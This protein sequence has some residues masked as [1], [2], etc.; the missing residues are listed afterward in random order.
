[1]KNNGRPTKLYRL[2]CRNG[3]YYG[4]LSS[5]TNF[6]STKMSK[7]TEAER[8]VLQWFKE[9]KEEKSQEDLLK[10]N[11][12]HFSKSFFLEES[13]YVQNLAAKGRKPTKAHLLNKQSHVKNYI[14]PKFGKLQLSDITPSIVD[15][16][17]LSLDLSNQTKN[18]IMAT[19]KTILDYAVYLGRLDTNP[20][21]HIKK[22]A[23]NKNQR[24]IFSQQELTTL[25]PLDNTEKALQIWGSHKWLSFFSLLAFT[26][27]RSGEIRG[28]TWND[29]ILKDG[30]AFISITKSAKAY[31][32]V[33]KTKS[34][35]EG[36]GY[37]PK[38][39]LLWLLE[40]KKLINNKS[41]DEYIFRKTNSAEPITQRGAGFVFHKALERANIDVA[42]RNIVP[43]SL[44]HT[45]TTL[46]LVNNISEET[47]I[48]STQHH[49]D[50][51]KL[52]THKNRE[53]YITQL[54]KYTDDIFSALTG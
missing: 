49:S 47:V 43:H 26:G 27:T 41:D 17:L 16:W 4:K 33:G 18:H 46:L 40:Y 39:I 6:I 34:S 29:I 22:Y 12:Y 19:L 45:Y 30:K 21:S 36:I 48:L 7:K 1:M 54:S 5:W 3:I 35:K 20:I 13:D 37:I 8:V 14:L 42:N 25:F 52:Y 53:N 38:Q 31:E 51:I 2:K 24:D 28:L 9:N 10:F 23:V 15:D 44:R 32:A 11:I 50:T